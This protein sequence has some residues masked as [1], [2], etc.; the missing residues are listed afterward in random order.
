VPNGRLAF[1]IMDVPSEVDGNVYSLGEKWATVSAENLRQDRVTSNDE[2]DA[3][4]AVALADKIEDYLVGNTTALIE[5]TIDEGRRML[6][7]LDAFLS[8][9]VGDVRDFYE[10]VSTWTA[11]VSAV[12]N[13]P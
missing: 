4:A 1:T 2:R 9:S 8:Y 13:L 7:M 6:L 12:P 3:E 11:E 10:I 5:V